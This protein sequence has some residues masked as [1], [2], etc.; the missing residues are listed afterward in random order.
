M[1][2]VENWK[3]AWK[4]LSVHFASLLIIWTMTSPED[5][6]VLLSLLGWAPETVTRLLAVATLAGRLV[7]QTK[8]EPS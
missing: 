7:G 3:D 4:W 8:K 5:Q 2:L 6:A 1:K